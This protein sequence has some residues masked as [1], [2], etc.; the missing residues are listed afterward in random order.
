MNKKNKLRRQEGKPINQNEIE[1]KLLTLQNDLAYL[2]EEI[3]EMVSDFQ[4]QPEKYDSLNL[5]E[6]MHAH[7]GEI[8]RIK[9][10]IDDFENKLLVE[11]SRLGR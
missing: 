10:E 4:R 5:R 2:S 9:N 6:L 7:N 3:E 8:S 1:Q 11:K